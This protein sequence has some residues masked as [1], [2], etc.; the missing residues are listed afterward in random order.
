MAD[1][2]APVTPEEVAVS[3]ARRE[4]ATAADALLLFYRAKFDKHEAELSTLQEHVRALDLAHADRAA[5]REELD[6]RDA[7]IVAHR[8]R[9]A[10]LESELLDAKERLMLRDPDRLNAPKCARELSRR[11]TS[12]D[13]ELMMNQ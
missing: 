12:D 1:V 9:C 6:G 8:R 7:E 5:W 4:E 3:C 10:V 13:N 11:R 2:A